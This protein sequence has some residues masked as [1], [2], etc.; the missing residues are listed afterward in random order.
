MEGGFAVLQLSA[1]MAEK[2]RLHEKVTIEQNE[3]GSMSLHVGKSQCLLRT[4]QSGRF[5]LFKRADDTAGLIT[6]LGDVSRLTMREQENNLQQSSDV[7]NKIR[8]V[9]KAMTFTTNT[10]YDLVE[11]QCWMEQGKEYKIDQSPD[12]IKL[13]SDNPGTFFGNVAMPAAAAVSMGPG[14]DDWQLDSGDDD[15]DD[16]VHDDDEM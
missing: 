15:D 13:L 16:G 7:E 4:Q 12:M 10:K 11:P 8:E 3:D 14:D 6:K 1:E 2:L 9:E 5:E